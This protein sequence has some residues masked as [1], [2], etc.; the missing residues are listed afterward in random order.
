[1]VFSGVVDNNQTTYDAAELTRTVR[2]KVEGAADWTYVENATEALVD[3]QTTFNVSV[4]GSKNATI[5]GWMTYHGLQSE[6]KTLTLYNGN[7]PSRVYGPVDGKSKLA[8]K[9]YGPVD[10]KSKNIVKLYGSVDGKSKAILG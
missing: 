1:M 4:P 6:V 2:Y 3:A 9:L 8:V 10:G 7:A 5:E